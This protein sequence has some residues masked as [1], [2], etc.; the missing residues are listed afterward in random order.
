MRVQVARCV[1]L[2]R[3]PQ[4]SWDVLARLHLQLPGSTQLAP[5]QLVWHHM[6]SC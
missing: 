5:Q 3:L 2:A 6:P 4:C 1:G